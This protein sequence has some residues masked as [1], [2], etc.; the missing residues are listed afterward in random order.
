MS[1]T[2]YSELN[3]AAANW[4]K[5]DDLTSRIPEFIALAE[6][7]FNRELRCRQ[8]EIRSTTSTD[9]T[10]DEPEMV[11][12]PG[13]FQ[14]M[15]SFRITS[16]SGKPRLAYMSD[17]QMDEHRERIGNVSGPPQFFSIF[18]SEIELCPTPE[19][20][21]T[22]EMKYRG[23]IP[24][25]TENNTT[26]WLLTFAPDV[27]LYGTLLE[28]TPYMKDDPRIAVW[29]GAMKAAIQSLNDLSQESGYGSGPLEMRTSGVTP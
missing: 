17:T 3:T 9:I 14:S 11:S 10:S 26:N 1:I 18:G 5:R 6:A 2:T 20:D 15:R 29:G 27:Y 21:Y 19:Q 25:L 13:D 23:I 16:I 24:A 8:M 12:L 22:L 7:K 4:L 28:A